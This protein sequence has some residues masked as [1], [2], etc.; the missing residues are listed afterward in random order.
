MLTALI[1]KHA[2]ALQTWLNTVGPHEDL[3]AEGEAYD[4][5]A[6]AEHAFVVFQCTTEAEV[7]QKLS[8]VASCPT[9]ADAVQVD[10]NREFLASILLPSNDVNPKLRQAIDTWKRADDSYR[11]AVSAD[12]ASDHDALWHAMDDAEAD[13]IAQPCLTPADIRAKVEI[14]LSNDNVFES[15]SSATYSA[16]PVERVLR[17]FLRSLLGPVEGH[18]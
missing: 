17:I 2:H 11:K 14:A 7:Q 13:M 9:L 18:P 5:F 6:D 10:L 16:E 4:A 15:L 1:E 12:Q 3:E 8:Y